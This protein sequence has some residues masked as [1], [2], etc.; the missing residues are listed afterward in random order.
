[1]TQDPKRPSNLQGFADGFHLPWSPR[2]TLGNPL[3]MEGFHSHG[4]FHDV[5]GDPQKCFFF[6]KGKSSIKNG[7][8]RDTPMTQVSP[9]CWGDEH[10]PSNSN[11]IVYHHIVSACSRDWW[12]HIPAELPELVSP[13][14]PFLSSSSTVAGWWNSHVLLQIK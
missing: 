5:M 13:K 8:F 12:L 7:L 4:A 3:K 10:L 9:P 6:F 1:M 2:S 14:C 11:Y